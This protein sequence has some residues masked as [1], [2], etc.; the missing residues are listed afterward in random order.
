[1]TTVYC[2][3]KSLY[4]DK[5]L[6]QLKYKVK[7]FVNTNAKNLNRKNINYIKKRKINTLHDINKF[8]K[9]KTNGLVKKV[10]ILEQIINFNF[11]SLNI[12]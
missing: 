8:E 6:K 1:M 4:T 3:I 9:I 10:Q 2:K 11:L 7:R 5:E 12:N